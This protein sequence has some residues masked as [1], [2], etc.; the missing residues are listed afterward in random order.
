MSAF[1]AE[2]T[3]LASHPAPI[4]ALAMPALLA[5]LSILLVWARSRG[6]LQEMAAGQLYSQTLVTAFEGVAVG[7]RDALPLAAII[8][9]GLASQS[10]AGELSRG[11]LRNLLLCPVGRINLAL[12]KA[13][14]M[15]SVAAA[16]YAL[17][18]LVAIGCS[19]AAFDFTDVAEQLEI[20]GSEPFVIT[21]AEALW[22]PFLI[23][24]PALLLPLFAYT[25]LGFLAG[26]M[27]TRGVTALALA[28]E[29]W[30]SSISFASRAARSDSRSTCCLRT[31]PPRWE[32][33]REPPTCSR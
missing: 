19:A 15:L 1:R 25:G 2:I 14:G 20:K 13:L 30:C 24:L 7:L 26:A 33:P 32:T 9:A 17:L 10:I 27:V 8:L 16:C 12:G 22:P 23:M 5:A 31:F 3:R 28:R 29:W 4:V 18:V 6:H 21:K 11:T